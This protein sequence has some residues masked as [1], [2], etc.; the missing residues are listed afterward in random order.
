MSTKNCHLPSASKRMKSLAT[1]VVDLRH[2]RKE[3]RLEIRNEALCAL[4]RTGRT[5]L[6]IVRNVQK[7]YEP[8]FWHRL[9]SRKA[10][11]RLTETCARR[12]SQQPSWGWQEP[13]AKMCAWLHVRPFT[14]IAYTLTSSHPTSQEQFLRALWEAVSRATVLIL[15]QIKLNSHVVLFF[16]RQRVYKDE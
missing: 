14:K 5:G 1:A 12:D 16:S 4:E 11:K 10:L 6:R 7:I 13:S 9:T 2:P 15:P 3:F 8:N